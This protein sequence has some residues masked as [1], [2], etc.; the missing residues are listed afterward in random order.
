MPFWNKKANYPSES[1][2]SILNGQYQ[3]HP[4][5]VRRNDS[6]KSLLAN[7]EYRWRV[8]IAVSLTNPNQHGLPIEPEMTLLSNI[9][10]ALQSNLESDQSAILVLVITTK[11]MRE[12]VFFTRV[13]DVEPAIAAVR[14]KFPNQT[15]HSYVKEDKDWNVYKQFYENK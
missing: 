6:A 2:W 9:E 12:F 15:L 8:G 1:K 5:F 3:G 4:L 10:A 7:S 14:V 11:G 13:P